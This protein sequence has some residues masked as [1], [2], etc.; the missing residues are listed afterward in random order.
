M[1]WGWMGK[2]GDT[3]KC[4]RI[5]RRPQSQL[6]ILDKGHNQSLPHVPE[7]I[8]TSHFE[9]TCKAWQRLRVSSLC[10]L[11]EFEAATMCILC[12]S[13]CLSFKNRAM[14]TQLKP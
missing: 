1:G 7:E 13:C 14:V 5:T 6:W 4:A 8:V 12:Y 3:W 11:D 2:T 9:E 10:G